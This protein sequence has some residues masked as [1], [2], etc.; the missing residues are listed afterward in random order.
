M[1]TITSRRRKPVNDAP[2]RMTRYVGSV[3]RVA[4]PGGSRGSPSPA[5][6]PGQQEDKCAR[7]ASIGDR[8]ILQEVAD[9][10][11]G[12]LAISW[13]N[14]INVSKMCN[15]LM[16]NVWSR[17]GSDEADDQKCV[18][19]GAE[20]AAEDEILNDYKIECYQGEEKEGRLG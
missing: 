20:T 11:R 9:V 17:Q 18:M 13:H 10:S 8:Q 19:E 3:Y 14:P 2:G 16:E 7:Q 15:E 1:M 6:R 5:G 4:A 12:R